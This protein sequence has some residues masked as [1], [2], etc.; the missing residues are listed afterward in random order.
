MPIAV[1]AL[2]VSMFAIGTIEFVIVGL[3]PT[4]AGDLDVSISAIGLVVT[5]YAL[6]LRSAGH[7]SPRGRHV[8]RASGCCWR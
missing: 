4:I 5:A 7:S 8:Y 2:A 6:G 1:V 3:L